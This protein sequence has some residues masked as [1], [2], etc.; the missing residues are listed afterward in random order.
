MMMA[1]LGIQQ[2]LSKYTEYMSYFPSLSPTLTLQ[3][4]VT[5]DSKW[6]RC[7]FCSLSFPSC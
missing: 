3:E 5:A 4:P 2:V 7:P 6:L 1:G